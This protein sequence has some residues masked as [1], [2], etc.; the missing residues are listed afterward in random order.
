MLRYTPSQLYT[1][2]RATICSQLRKYS[3]HRANSLAMPL[4]APVTMNVL[5]TVFVGSIGSWG[6]GNR[7]RDRSFCKSTRECPGLQ[8]SRAIS[9]K[10]P[11]TRIQTNLG[12]VLLGRV[13]LSPG[14]FPHGLFARV[15]GAFQMTLT[16]LYLSNDQDCG[17][18]T[19]S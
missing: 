14:G 5:P 6:R 17:S 11:G 9:V 10:V 16:G 4:L 18:K 3:A 8:E 1:W 7:H 13:A 2:N 15:G 19:R 12:F